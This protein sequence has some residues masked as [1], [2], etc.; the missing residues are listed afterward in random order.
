[1]KIL[2][3]AFVVS[4]AGCSCHPDHLHFNPAGSREFGKHY[5]EKMLSLPGYNFG[6]PGAKT[7]AK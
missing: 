7:A 4:S 1:M 5:A 2:P 3:N 6:E